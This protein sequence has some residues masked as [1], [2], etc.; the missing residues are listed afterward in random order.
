MVYG[1]IW[2]LGDIAEYGGEQGQLEGIGLF[3]VQLRREDG[4]IVRV[5]HLMSLWKATRVYAPPKG[6]EPNH[7][8]SLSEEGES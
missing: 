6:L 8:A 5:P 4:A 7:P 3:D 2:H 1:Q